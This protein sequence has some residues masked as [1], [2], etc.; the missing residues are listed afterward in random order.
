MASSIVTDDVTIVC[1]EEEKL[2]ITCPKL[3]KLPIDR[4]QLDKTPP[5]AVLALYAFATLGEPSDQPMKFD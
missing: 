4:I 3:E 2:S 5:P 1:D